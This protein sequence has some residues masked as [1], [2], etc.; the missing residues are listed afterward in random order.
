VTWSSKLPGAKHKELVVKDRKESPQQCATQWPHD[1]EQLK[2]EMEQHAWSCNHLRAEIVVLTVV[3]VVWVVDLCMRPDTNEESVL[4]AEAWR[5]RS[6]L[7]DR[8]GGGHATYSLNN[9]L[10]T[11]VVA[12]PGMLLHF[13]FQL[14]FIVWPLCCALLWT[15]LAI[16][17]NELFVLG[18]RKFGTPRH[19]CILVAWGYETQQRLMWTKVLFC[20]I[21]YV[22]SFVSFLWFSVSQH[23]KYQQMDM[24]E[25]T[26]KD[27]ALE[28]KGLPSLPGSDRE[29][30]ATL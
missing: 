6:K 26:M 28:L 15:F 4:Q 5:S 22:G 14:F 13:R 20:A 23:R 2:A 25:K 12:G 3:V 16:F 1:E 27:Y 21:V 29:E 30:K 11:K 10:C 9:N 18:T 19:N 7:I 17:H 24:S 8:E